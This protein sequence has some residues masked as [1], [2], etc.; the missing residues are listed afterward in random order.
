M[1]MQLI[2]LF[3]LLGDTDVNKTDKAL[4]SR[5]LPSCVKKLKVNITCKKISNMSNDDKDHGEHTAVM[6]DRM[7]WYRFGSRL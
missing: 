3:W 7:Y 1:F 2:N 4:T 6:E 5:R